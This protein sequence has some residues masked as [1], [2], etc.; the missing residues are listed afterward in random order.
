MTEISAKEVFDRRLPLYAY[1]EPLLVG[2]RVLE[3]GT[4]TGAGTA[5]LATNGATSVV[6]V[7][8]VDANIE[9]AHARRAPNL[10]FRKVGSLLDV[11]PGAPFDVVLAPEA[12][13]LLRRPEAIPALARLLAPGGRLVL[14]A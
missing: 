13:E 9:R 5:H 2:R 8:V 12:E 7:D 14:V 4:G 6:S 3:L 11:V 1:L 10:T